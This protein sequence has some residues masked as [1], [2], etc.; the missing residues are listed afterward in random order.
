MAAGLKGNEAVAPPY[1]GIGIGIAIEIA[2]E[3]CWPERPDGCRAQGQRGRCPS[4]P[5]SLVA[6]SR[7]QRVIDTRDVN[8]VQWTWANSATRPLGHLATL[9]L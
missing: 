4:T 5:M 8:A 3:G 9:L 6:G 7:F 2:M 1:F